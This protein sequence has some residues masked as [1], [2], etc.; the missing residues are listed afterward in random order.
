M[1]NTM[2]NKAPYNS[3]EAR[4][5]LSIALC[6]FLLLLLAS[7]TD[8]DI[9]TDTAVDTTSS[10]TEPLRFTLN[11]ASTRL[12]YD[13]LSSYFEDGESIGCVLATS[14]TDDD[15]NTSYSFLAN[16]KWIV[17]KTTDDSG[18]TYSL[19][20]SQIY[21]G[22]TADDGNS[23][24]YTAY[25]PLTDT[26]SLLSTDSDGYLSVNYSDG[27][28]F[29]FFYYPF[30]D[31]PVTSGETTTA[32]DLTYVPYSDTTSDDSST[33]TRTYLMGPAYSSTI[34]NTSST[35]TTETDDEGNSVTYSPQTT[36][37]ACFTAFPA[38]VHTDQSTA[39]CHNYSDFL[40]ASYTNSDSGVTSDNIGDLGDQAITFAKK[41][42]TLRVRSDK[43]LYD[44][45]IR[46]WTTSTSTSEETSTDQA[47]LSVTS[48]GSTYT[49]QLTDGDTTTSYSVTGTDDTY[50]LS[51][52][53]DSGTTTNI[54]LTVSNTTIT[55]CTITLTASTSST[56]QSTGTI[57]TIT[58]V[59]TYSYSST[60]GDDDSSSSTDSSSS[61]SLS[62][63]VTTTTTTQTPQNIAIGQQ[64][65][66]TTD[67]LTA[68][69]GTTSDSSIP[70]ESLYLLPTGTS[71]DDAT[72]LYPYDNSAA[73]SSDEDYPYEYRFVLPA[74][75]SF[76]GT[77][78]F[79]TSD[80][81]ES[82]DLEYTTQ[83]L[84]D[85][86]S[87]LTVGKA[88]N[89]NYKVYLIYCYFSSTSTMYTSDEGYFSYSG[90]IK[91]DAE[92]GPTIS[93]ET[94]T[95]K[96]GLSSTS[97]ALTLTLPEKLLVT[98][99]FGK[100]ESRAKILVTDSSN[101]TTTY[102]PTEGTVEAYS[103]DNTA[104]I[105]T[106]LSFYLETGT[107]TLSKH[108]S[109]GSQQIYCVTLKRSS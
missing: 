77:L 80:P 81:D 31:L 65:D 90:T 44:V 60:D 34:V 54:S 1:M 16:S 61:L 45:H 70:Q 78:Y 73:Y 88:Y 84:T 63:T 39:T 28:V 41:T 51:T 13:D 5:P 32:A 107:Y 23:V 66:L 47:T 7:C 85:F 9:L 104:D 25:D 43:Q 69:S 100:S 101:T 105:G 20:V 21:T 53:D 68:Y 46:P 67:T 99:Y 82:N 56:D 86:N 22:T 58:T 96:L 97:G 26:S 42:A 62:K 27:P 89:V 40:W 74:Q 83:A 102:S 10:T 91:E 19:V 4:R 71:P 12:T 57:T 6:F 59:T 8:N 49:L 92:N 94:Y 30:V 55:A 50:T 48:S 2:K 72:C 75:S 76:D 108:S 17:G 37:A 98:L 106:Y 35:T 87:E 18:T 29:F 52:T 36:D 11:Q 95:Y 109:S 38:F 24:T 64:I 79:Y 15:G 93:G 3:C 103:L 33:T 14:T